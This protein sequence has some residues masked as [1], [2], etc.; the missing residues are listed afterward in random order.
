[1]ESTRQDVDD[2]HD[3]CEELGI[4]HRQVNFGP[5]APKS[6]AQKIVILIVARGHQDCR[7]ILIDVTD[8]TPRANTE[9]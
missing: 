5:K 4:R 2:L 8:K 6:T 9:P 1:M 7:A 3:L